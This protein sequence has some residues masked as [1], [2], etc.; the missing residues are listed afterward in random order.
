MECFHVAVNHTDRTIK[1]SECKRRRKAAP[2][3]SG[4]WRGGKTESTRALR[5]K[6]ESQLF[7]NALTVLYRREH[8]KK[9]L[10]YSDEPLEELPDVS[11][12]A[13]V[14]HINQREREQNHSRMF[15]F[16]L[17]SP[18]IRHT[19]LRRFAGYTVLMNYCLLD[20]VNPLT[21][22]EGELTA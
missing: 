4:L 6:Q 15:S 17:A 18:N 10:S 3:L 5:V 19:S 12:E 20:I 8:I 2:Y 11:R 14:Q 21:L 9:K 16:L 22:V 7:M 13:A 1:L